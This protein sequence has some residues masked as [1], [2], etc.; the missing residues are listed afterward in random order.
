M[1]KKVK[2]EMWVKW[3]KKWKTKIILT[4]EKMHCDVFTESIIS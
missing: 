3:K 2:H 4:A 1:K